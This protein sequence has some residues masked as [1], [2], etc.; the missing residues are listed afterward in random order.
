MFGRPPGT[1]TPN[2]TL[3]RRLLCAVE[4]TARVVR[5]LG[6]AAAPVE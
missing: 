2:P 4:L 5:P 1:R 6:G 3:K